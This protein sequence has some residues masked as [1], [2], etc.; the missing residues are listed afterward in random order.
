[1]VAEWFS[2]GW[3]NNKEQLQQKLLG[4]FDTGSSGR[5]LLLFWLGTTKQPL[6]VTVTEAT[7][8]LCVGNAAVVA[9]KWFEF[10]KGGGDNEHCFLCVVLMDFQL[11]WKTN[12]DGKNVG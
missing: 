5:M 10:R 4:D 2:C 9:D 6:T 3:I 12:S 1:M 7:H 11:E 8:F